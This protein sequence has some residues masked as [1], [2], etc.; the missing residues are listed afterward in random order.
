ML[1]K[2][3]T[4][5]SFAKMGTAEG[6]L[7]GHAPFFRYG[8]SPRNTTNNMRKHRNFSHPLSYS[9]SH[10]Y[11]R[12]HINIVDWQK[13]EEAAKI[14]KQV[15]IPDNVVRIRP[16]EIVGHEGKHAPSNNV[17]CLVRKQ[18][19]GLCFNIRSIGVLLICGAFVYKRFS[20]YFFCL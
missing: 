16:R 5:E 10:R 17:L 7:V 18:C 3:P 19:S 15:N 20:F 6:A 2:K 1:I 13:K 11:T 14:R 12:M 8:L 4:P 9:S